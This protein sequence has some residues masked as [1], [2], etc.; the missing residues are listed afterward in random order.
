ML[1]DSPIKPP[2]PVVREEPLVIEA[3]QT[4][5]QCPMSAHYSSPSHGGSSSQDNRRSSLGQASLSSETQSHGHRGSSQAPESE[6]GGSPN[7]SLYAKLGG[8][9][10]LEAA[11]DMFYDRILDDERLKHFFNGT[12]MM[13]LVIKQVWPQLS[14]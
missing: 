13:R 3:D 12:N 2:P 14:C 9:E 5:A 11:V 1:A 8:P 6:S 7:G 4:P 10:A